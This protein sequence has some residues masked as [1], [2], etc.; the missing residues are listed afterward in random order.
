[1]AYVPEIE[2]PVLFMTGEDNH[3][4]TDSNI[5]AYETV[6]KMVPGRHQLATFPNYGHQDVFMG[7]NVAV[8]VFP[9]LVEFINDHR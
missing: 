1:M 9:R 7:K 6:N 4:F 3:V 2:T 8:D 5:V